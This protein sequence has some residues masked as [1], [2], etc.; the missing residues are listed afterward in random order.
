MTK[1]GKNGNCKISEILAWAN[2]GASG[3]SMEEIART[4][5]PEILND[6]IETY[7]HLGGQRDAFLWKWV[8]ENLHYYTLSSVSPSE[9]ENIITLKTLLTIFVAIFD[10]I[11]DVDRDVQTIYEMQKLPHHIELIDMNMISEKNKQLFA[12]S[13]DIWR[14]FIAAIREYPNFF[15]F[16]DMLFFDV[17]Q[18]INSF[19]YFTIVNQNLSLMSYSESATYGYHNMMMI[20]YCDIDLMASENIINEEVPILREIFWRGQKMGRI[21]NWLTTWERELKD[22]DYSSGIFAYQ[23]VKRE[24]PE[25][26][27]LQPKSEIIKAINNSHAQEHFYAEWQQYYDEIKHLGESVQSIDV[28]AYL[29]ALENLLKSHILSSGLK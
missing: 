9:R 17:K 2:N 26:G 20:I 1:F 24:L 29:L 12:L 4:A 3:I 15:Y 14:Y 6:F 27:P 23:L 7:E 8:Y 13:L 28:D 19:L 25:T 5:L 16:E 11:A 22:D 10:D 18:M 21:G